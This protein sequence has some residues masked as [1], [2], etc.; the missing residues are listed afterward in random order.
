MNK[1]IIDIANSDMPVAERI[2]E[3][4]AKL[5]P[6]Q[7][8]D[9]LEKMTEAEFVDHRVDIFLSELEAALLSD[10]YTPGGAEEVAYKECMAGLE[11]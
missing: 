1:S 5:N 6:E 3:A 2:R 11:A 9:V 10:K 7:K 4:L 8:R